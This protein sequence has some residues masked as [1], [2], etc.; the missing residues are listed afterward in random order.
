MIGQ[1]GEQIIASNHR[2]S[3]RRVPRKLEPTLHSHGQPRRHR[4]AHHRNYRSPGIKLTL[5]T[6]N[7]K[8]GKHPGVPPFAI[9]PQ[10][11]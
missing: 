2:R 5:Q 11:R 10:S 3:G 8:R 1:N 6:E 9:L 4:M 7:R